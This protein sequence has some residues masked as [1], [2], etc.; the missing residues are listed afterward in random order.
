MY[1]RRPDGRTTMQ[2]FWPIQSRSIHAVLAF[3]TWIKQMVHS[4]CESITYIYQKHT[5]EMDNTNEDPPD[6]ELDELEN[7][8]DNLEA[9]LLRKVEEYK[10]IFLAG[11]ENLKKC[12][13]ASEKELGEKRA[14]VQNYLRQLTEMETALE[15]ERSDNKTNMNELK[16]E[17]DRL[18]RLKNER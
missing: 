4:V 15:K 1:C 8:F 2:S 14:E 7:Y 3:N 5:D 18:V 9:Q 10:S 11:S 12:L 6:I 17:R 16:T 13:D